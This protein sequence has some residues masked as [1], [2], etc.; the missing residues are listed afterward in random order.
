MNIK[1]NLLFFYGLECPHCLHMEKLVNKLMK[2]GYQVEKVEIWHN[3]DNNKLLEK[4]D[5]EDEPCGGVPFF[6]NQK[7][8]K[9]LCGEVTMKEIQEWADGE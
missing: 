2:E 8:K 4:L 3:E 7:S 5:C 1:T 9:T 6:L